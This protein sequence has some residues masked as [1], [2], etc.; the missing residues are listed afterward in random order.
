MEKV[1]VLCPTK[2]TTIPAGHTAVVAVKRPDGA[3]RLV[4]VLVRAQVFED[5]A[6]PIPEAAPNESVPKAE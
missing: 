1:A 6:A 4:L 2:R 5:P 3:N